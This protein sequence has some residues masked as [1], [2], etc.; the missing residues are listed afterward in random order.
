M[1][2]KELLKDW[3]SNI[4]TSEFANNPIVGLA[5]NSRDI[6]EGYVFIALAGSKQHGM[7]Y[8]DQAIL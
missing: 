4:E 6:K 7:A 8:V 5:L 1:T 2:L 3:V